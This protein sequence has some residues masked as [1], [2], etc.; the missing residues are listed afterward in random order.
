VARLPSWIESDQVVDFIPPGPAIDVALADQ[1]FRTWLEAAGRTGWVN[2]SRTLD[3]EAG[4]WEIGLF[5]DGGPG[6]YASV[7]FD[8]R[9]GEVLE[10]R[11]E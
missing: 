3:L 4:T 10:H 9:T 7:T 11:F 5:R 6:F 8:A 1:Q 2:S